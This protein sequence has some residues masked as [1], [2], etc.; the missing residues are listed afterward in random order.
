MRIKFSVG[1][2]VSLS[3]HRAVEVLGIF[4]S[5]NCDGIL[6][7]FSDGSEK[8]LKFLYLSGSNVTRTKLEIQKYQDQLVRAG[9]RVA[10]T[11]F[12]EKRLNNAYSYLILVQP[13]LGP[14]L[15]D[16]LEEKD[17]PGEQALEKKKLSKL[18]LDKLIT[19]AL[20]S[21]YFKLSRRSWRSRENPLRTLVGVDPLPR[22]MLLSSTGKYFV[23][24]DL[25]PVKM[26]KDCGQHMLE[27]IE[28][29]S[30]VAK[31]LGIFRNYNLAGMIVAFCCNL[32]ALRPAWARRCLIRVKQY[33]RFHKQDLVIEEIEKYFS[34]ILEPIRAKGKKLHQLSSMDVLD[35]VADWKFPDVLRLRGFACLLAGCARSAEQ[36]A[37]IKTKVNKVWDLTHFQSDELPDAELEDAKM[38]MAEIV[39]ILH[40]S[41]AKRVSKAL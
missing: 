18:E 6:A 9:L 37:L 14:S 41:S 40:A 19:L 35:I 2:W 32:M 23:F 26:I 10:K 38:T 27:L 15:Q 1:Q 12:L 20:D 25:V 7:R 24:C 3:G 34:S 4:D 13:C 8:V 31:S 39:D 22:N 11:E 21:W 33:L 30:E 5:H 16:L 28:P 36:E 17:V 29:T